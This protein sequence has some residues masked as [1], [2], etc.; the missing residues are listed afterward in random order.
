M[1]NIISCKPITLDGFIAGPNGE[2]NW[3]SINQDIFDHVEQRISKTNTAL[4]G[5]TTYGMMEVYCQ[6]V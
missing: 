2:T 1:G 6:A 4:Y 3:I 5:K